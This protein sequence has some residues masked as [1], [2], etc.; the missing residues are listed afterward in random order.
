[1]YSNF[2]IDSKESICANSKS[3]NACRQ[4]C[5]YS[6]ILSTPNNSNLKDKC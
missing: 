6:Q 1:M 2:Y 4:P 3:E 5:A